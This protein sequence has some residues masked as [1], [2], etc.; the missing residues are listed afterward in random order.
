V[1]RERRLAGGLIARYE[2]DLSGLRVLTE[3]ASGPYLHTPLLA[4]LAGAEHVYAWTRDSSFATAADVRAATDRAAR[5]WGL[6]HRVEVVD[7]RPLEQVAGADVVTNSGFVRPIDAAMVG[8]MKPTA[9]VP[10]MWETWEFRDSDIDLAACR[11]RGVLV[12]GTREGEPPCDMR[13]YAAAMGVKLAFELGA[14]VHGSRILLLGAQPTLGRPIR[15]ALEALG[16][17]VTWL[18]APYDAAPGVDLGGM[19]AVIVA[20]HQS[21][22]ALLGGDGALIHAEELAAANPSVAIGVV[23]GN[24]D[25]DA[26]RAA[27]LRVVPDHVR[28]PGFMSYQPSELGPLP[29]L[30]LYAAGLKVGQEMARARLGGLDPAAAAAVAL[31]RSPAMDFA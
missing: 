7:G 18:G 30:D 5:D 19:D 3:A 27:G 28:P 20:E 25:D 9:V 21:D 15:D 24:V 10:L 17:E 13:G 23:A 11:A 1:T 4:A 8:A 22:R 2:I 16:A 12:L 31:E 26:L 29:V 14:E 6:A